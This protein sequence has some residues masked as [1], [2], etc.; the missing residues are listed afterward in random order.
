MLS[1]ELS[2]VGELGGSLSTPAGELGRSLSA[3][4]DELAGSLRF[5]EG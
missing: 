5:S 1:L 4:V 2:P 3:P